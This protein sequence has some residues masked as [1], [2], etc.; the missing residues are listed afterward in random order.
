[1]NAHLE[2]FHGSI[3]AECLDRLILFGENMLRNAIQQY[4]IYYHG[5]RNHQGIGNR[6]IEPGANVGRKA[7]S[8]AGNG[9]EVCSTIIIE[10]SPEGNRDVRL[11][12]TAAHQLGRS[13]PERS[14]E[15]VAGGAGERGAD[16][17]RRAFDTHRRS[18]AA[19]RR[20]EW[21]PHEQIVLL[22][23]GKTFTDGILQHAA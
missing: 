8:D 5:E 10:M 13:L 19:P 14:T 16:V 21:A 17:P 9:S 18:R 20:P 11:V 4:L 1:L 6:L 23:Q 15:N 2:R 7:P 22:I 3:K 12:E